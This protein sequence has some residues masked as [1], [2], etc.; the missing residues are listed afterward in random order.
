MLLPRAIGGRSGEGTLMGANAE[1]CL[2]EVNITFGRERCDFPFRAHALSARENN[3]DE[4]SHEMKAHAAEARL[5]TFRFC[6][7]GPQ[8]RHRWID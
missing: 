8:L 7:S 5:S 6:V 1:I 4:R 2:R 3:F